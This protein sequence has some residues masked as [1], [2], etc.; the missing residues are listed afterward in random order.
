VTDLEVDGHLA[1]FVGLAA[2]ENM[3]ALNQSL[4]ALRERL[5]IISNEVQAQRFDLADYDLA[6]L[7]EL[8]RSFREKLKIG[9]SGVAWPPDHSP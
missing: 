7:M 2:D 6:F 5:R 4:E 3:L 9:F 8:A 1:Q